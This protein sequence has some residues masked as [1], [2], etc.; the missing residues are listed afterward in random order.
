MNISSSLDRLKKTLG[1]NCDEQNAP[2]RAPLTMQPAFYD[3]A[4]FPEYKDFTTMQWY[5]ENQK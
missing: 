3:F 4:H 1:F 2:T 5:Y